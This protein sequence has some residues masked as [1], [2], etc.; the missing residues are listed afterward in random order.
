[1]EKVK[2]KFESST[3][4]SYTNILNKAVNLSFYE[5][6]GNPE[7][8]NHEV[9]TYRNVSQDMVIEA[10]RRYLVPSN[11]STIYYKSTGKNKK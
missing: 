9:D 10:T 1:M 6:L 5:L 8:I 4:F 2:N 3:V 7:L 11:C